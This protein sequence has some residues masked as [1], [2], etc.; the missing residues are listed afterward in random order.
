MT[1][2]HGQMWKRTPHPAPLG[3]PPFPQRPRHAEGL[4]SASGE[5]QL[6]PQS[7]G[8]AWTAPASGFTEKNQ[9]KAP[10][11]QAGA[12]TFNQADTVPHIW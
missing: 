3:V 10:Q 7:R 5:A 1:R 4:V 11:G 9:T 12:L 6:L 2:G 8:K